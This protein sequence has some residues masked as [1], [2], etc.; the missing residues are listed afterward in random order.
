MSLVKRLLF[1]SSIVLVL[2]A[3]GVFVGIVV[4]VTTPSQY[5]WRCGC[6]VEPYM[7]DD[8]GNWIRID[9]VKNPEEYKRAL[10]VLG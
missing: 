3:G 7:R 8:K 10:A 2:G 1:V 5:E 4:Q 6:A 9:P